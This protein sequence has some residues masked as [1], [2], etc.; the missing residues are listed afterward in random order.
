MKF[1]LA[2]ALYRLG[3]L[4]P[5]KLGDVGVA[6]LESGDDTPAVRQLAGLDASATW[7]DVEDLFDRV[8]TEL[9]R[10]PVTE[11]EAAYV[12]AEAAAMDIV[13]GRVTPYEGAAPGMESASASFVA[14]ATP[15]CRWASTSATIHR[16]STRSR[17]SVP[18]AR[19]IPVRSAATDGQAERFDRR[20]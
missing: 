15:S 13:A 7:R 12:V 10:R 9:S 19:T 5:E 6:L 3:Q 20:L 17:H 18:T 1:E 8:L 4:G 2:E 11:I 16:F 14:R